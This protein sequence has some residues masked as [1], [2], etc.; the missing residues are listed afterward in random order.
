LAVFTIRRKWN[1]VPIWLFLHGIEP[2]I[3]RMFAS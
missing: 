1:S 3:G 2:N